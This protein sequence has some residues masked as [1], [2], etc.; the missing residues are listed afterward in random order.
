MLFKYGLII[1]FSFLNRF[2]CFYLNSG[3]NTIN[4]FLYIS[5][6]LKYDKQ[7]K[8][9]LCS[10]SEGPYCYFTD[11][12]QN[13][14]KESY[15]NLLNKLDKFS[16]N[17]KD[18]YSKLID[19]EQNPQNE[20][21][22]VLITFDD[23][24]TYKG[25]YLEKLTNIFYYEK[26][27]VDFEGKLRLTKDDDNNILENNLNII[28]KEYPSNLYGIIESDYITISFKGKFFISNFCYI[29]AHNNEDKIEKIN[30]YGYI[31]D[32]LIY[33]YT[34]TDD[35]KRK[36]K[37]LKVFFPERIKVNK[38]VITGPYDIDNICFTFDYN[39]NLGENDVYYLYNYRID[40][41]LVD[42]D[43]I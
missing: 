30:F 1:L 33:G 14:K 9:K 36:E 43:D 2:K 3:I 19:K 38:L 32:K 10:L 15:A 16:K 5:R 8:L 13:I 18:S 21:L 11:K 17:Y 7:N 12:K 31:G 25:M 20:E 28:N 29:K 37:W 26:L 39:I 24:T 40:N 41:Y 34:F 27:I 35:K 42:N 22:N 23:D 4:K 6:V